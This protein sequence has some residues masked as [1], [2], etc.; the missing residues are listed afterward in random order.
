MDP[1]WNHEN[2]ESFQ[3]D[4][5]DNESIASNGDNSKVSLVLFYRIGKAQI[6]L[7]QNYS[8]YIHGSLDI[9]IQTWFSS[10]LIQSCDNS[11]G[12]TILRC[13]KEG[14]NSFVHWK[15]NRWCG[16]QRYTTLV[17]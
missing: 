2:R 12:L 6:K 9:K 7:D 15:G 11:F 1:R 13:H 16:R 5:P 10:E 3:S 8:K 17:W 14:L 4:G